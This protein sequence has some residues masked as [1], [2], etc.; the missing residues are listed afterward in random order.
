MCNNAEVFPGP[1]VACQADHATAL[2]DHGY[3]TYVVSPKESARSSLAPPSWVPP[4]ATWLPW[5]DQNIANALLFREL[6]PIPGFA[7]TGD[8]YPKGVYCDKTSSSSRDGKGALQP[9]A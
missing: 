3:Y 1:V 8:Y 2:D 4:D 6:L 7:L 5:G 9:Q